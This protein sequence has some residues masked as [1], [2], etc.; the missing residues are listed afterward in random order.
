MQLKP[1]HDLL[2]LTIDKQPF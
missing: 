1:A 2:A